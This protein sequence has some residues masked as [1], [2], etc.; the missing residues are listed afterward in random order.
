MNK[1]E[2]TALLQEQI[3]KCESNNFAALGYKEEK[4]W[5][6]PMAGFASGS[7]PL[8]QFYKEDIGDFYMTPA[9]VFKTKYED[10]DVK[11]G[12]LTII[13]LAYAQSEATKKEQSQQK[14]EPCMRWMYSRNSWKVLVGELYANIASALSEQGIRFVIPDLMPQMKIHK[15]E[16]YGLASPW[17]QRHTAYIAGLGTFGLTKGLLTKQGAAMRFISVVTDQRFEPDKREY[18]NY[19]DWCLQCGA[20]IKRC[21]TGAIT[22][23][24]NDKVKCKAYL[25]KMGEKHL[26]NPVFDPTV[27]V[28]CGLCQSKTPCADHVPVKI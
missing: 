8:F 19:Q 7:D 14:D 15:T 3:E 16:K 26:K 22:K 25:D 9:E 23:E 10:A 5:G 28:G 12:D 18:E 4:M 27:E 6:K 1:Q 21:P 13:S 17:S 11:D 2:I 20:C 24:G